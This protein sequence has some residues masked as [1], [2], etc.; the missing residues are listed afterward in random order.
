[1]SKDSNAI[2]YLAFLRGINVG[3]HRKIKMKDLQLS[4]AKMGFDEVKTY[5]QSGNIVFKAAE[6]KA[7]TLSKEIEARIVK[8]FGFEVKVIIKNRAQLKEIISNNPYLPDDSANISKCYLTLL[9]EVPKKEQA[10]VLNA[11]KFPHDEFHLMDNIIYLYCTNGYGKTKLS[12]DFFEKKLK[13][14][15]TTRNWKTMLKM[16]EM[17]DNV[18]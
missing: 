16:L 10:E 12:N 9:T 11:L 14:A 4:L 17:S 13:Q 15:A 7:D 6:D 3:G 5:I 1:M 8:D 2:A 18:N